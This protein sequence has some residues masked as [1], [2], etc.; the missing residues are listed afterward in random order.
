MPPWL[1]EPRATLLATLGRHKEALTILTHDAK[2]IDAAERYCDDLPPAQRN[3]SLTSLVSTCLEGYA[4]DPSLVSKAASLVLHR[5]CA[6]LDTMSALRGVPAAAALSAFVP[7]LSA[8]VSAGNGRLSAARLARA[9]LRGEILRAR[10]DLARQRRRSVT[11]TRETVCVECRKRIG[12]AVFVSS[13]DETISHYACYR[14][15]G[16]D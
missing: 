1:W 5:G 13:P 2:D 15:L 6:A 7:Y 12:D 9:M 8:A 10:G 4:T 16:H 3:T 11:I 14:D